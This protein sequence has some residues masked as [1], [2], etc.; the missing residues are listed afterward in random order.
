MPKSVRVRVP[1]LILNI[2]ILIRYG[3]KVR[4]TTDLSDYA[5]G[6]VVGIEGITCDPEKWGMMGAV[7]VKF[8][9]GIQLDVF[10]RSLEIIEE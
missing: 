2:L 1:P 6:L 10:P 7:G 9:N 5:E 8:T 4:L 3:T